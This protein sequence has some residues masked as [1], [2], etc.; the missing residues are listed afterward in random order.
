ME[1]LDALGLVAR[2]VIEE[3][4]KLDF[5]LLLVFDDAG[6]FKALCAPNRGEDRRQI[7]ELLC[8]QRDQLVAGLRTKRRLFLCEVGIGRRLRV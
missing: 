1:H 4:R 2:T 5:R 3:L 7:G 8:L 6:A